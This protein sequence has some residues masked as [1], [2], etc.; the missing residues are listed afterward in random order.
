MNL[1][2][3]YNGLHL[4]L[5]SSLCNS[6]STKLRMVARRLALGMPFVDLRLRFSDEA[7]GKASVKSGSMLPP[8]DIPGVRELDDS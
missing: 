6:S 3:G 1:L 5:T 8:G 2:K 7:S 4:R